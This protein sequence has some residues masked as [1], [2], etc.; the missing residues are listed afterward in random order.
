M[1]PK[2]RHTHLHFG[3]LICSI[4]NLSSFKDLIIWLRK[5][6]PPKR[7][8]AST[9]E[10]LPHSFLKFSIFLLHFFLVLNF[11]FSLCVVHFLDSSAYCLGY[12]V[13]RRCFQLFCVVALDIMPPSYLVSKQKTN[14]LSSKKYQSESF[15][16]ISC[17]VLIFVSEFSS[18]IPPIFL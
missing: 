14:S 16:K 11:L 7:N 5:S 1:E 18:S 10:T 6:P 8:F 15:L 9:A 2:R 4:H 13:Y 17:R 3:T 12:I